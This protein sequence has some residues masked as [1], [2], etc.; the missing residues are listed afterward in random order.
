MS[1]IKCP[2]CGEEISSIS[3]RCINCGYILN[4]KISNLYKSG[5]IINIIS[6]SL[7]I[8]LIIILLMYILIPQ[9]QYKENDNY[10]DYDF[11]IEFSFE[12]KEQTEESKN[13]QNKLVLLFIFSATS[14]FIISIISLK[15]IGNKLVNSILMFSLSILTYPGILYVYD[16]CCIV[17]F[18][19]I[20]ILFTIG[21]LFCIIGSKNDKKNI[22]QLV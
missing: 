18:I 3:N 7:V 2:E 4:N 20:P 19:F 21:G 10:E 11:K 13:I 22:K 6:S 12:E 8:C 5:C 17:V 14:I 16:T 9:V 15:G 1:I